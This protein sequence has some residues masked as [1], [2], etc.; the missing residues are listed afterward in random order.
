[1]YR[2]FGRHNLVDLKGFDCLVHETDTDVADSSLRGLDALAN[3][4]TA[5]HVL[6]R[7]GHLLLVHDQGL[8]T[9]VGA[10]AAVAADDHNL[11]V[12]AADL[13]PTVDLRAV[14]RANQCHR[15]SFDR[16]AG[17]HDDGDPVNGH[18]VAGWNT[19][20]LDRCLDPSVFHDPRHGGHV[21]GAV[22]QRFGS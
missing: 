3:G 6:H 18:C 11:G 2:D 21:A 10:A 19:A 1:G 14:D 13:G 5:A 12:R 20:L 4:A 9:L 17:V 8:K 15:Q 7:P 16:V 22:D